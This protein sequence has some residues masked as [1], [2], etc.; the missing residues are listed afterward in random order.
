MGMALAAGATGLAACTAPSD[1]NTG[2]PTKITMLVLGDKPTNGRLQKMLEKLNV[3]L[4]QKANATLDLFYIEWADWQTQY[5]VQLLSGD[6]KIDLITTATDWL[7]AFENAQ[8][9]AFL[10]LDEEILKANAPKTWEGVAAKGNWEVCKLSDGQIYFIPEDNYT[11]WTNH[12]FFYRG[13]WAKSA[14]IPDGTITQF[15]QFTQYFSWVKQNHKKAY[16]WDVAGANESALTGYL[17]GHSDGQ[18]IQQVSA[19][20]YY[21]F[22]TTAAAPFIVGSWYMESP[23]LIEAAKLAKEWNDIGVWREDAINYDGETREA[24]YSGRSGADQHHTQTFV[25]GVWYN[26]SN[27]QKGS[28]PKMFW[29]GAETKNIFRDIK[30]HGAM[31]VSANSK[32]PEKALQVYD[33]IRN[34]EECYKLLNFGIEGSDYVMKDG[35]LGY[36]EGYDPSKDGLGANFWGGRM[37]EFE[38]QRVAD[39]PDKNALYTQL[40]GLSKDY[41]Y[42]TLLIN[43]DMIDPGLAAMGSVLS[44]FIPQLQYGK[45]KDPEAFIAEMRKELDTAGYHDIKQSIQQDLDKWAGEKGLK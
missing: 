36:P 20:N 15:E 43:K 44:R 19:G 40:E 6:P 26:L 28:D 16:P 37:D 7:F 32:N 3:A 38:P 22:Q 9:G 21:P 41:P 31:A 45:A 17:Q 23:Q 1:D 39:D 34:D 10:G 29:F 8:K 5:N 25:T 4:T 33:L 24:L 18:T 42:S 14:G 13:D 35:K 11:Q 12:G 30:T 2:A 27:R